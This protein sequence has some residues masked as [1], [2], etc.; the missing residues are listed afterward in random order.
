MNIF[1]IIGNEILFNFMWWTTYSCSPDLNVINKRL[2]PIIAHD[3]T[4]CCVTPY[5]LINRLKF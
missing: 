1:G 4:I 5:I 2:S 3:S